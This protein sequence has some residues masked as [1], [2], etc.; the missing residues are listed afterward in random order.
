MYRQAQKVHFVG[1]GGI[2]MSGIAELL[3]NLGHQVS[4][5]DLKESAITRRLSEL[6]ATIYVGHHPD[7]VE[8]AEVVVYSSAV[9]PDNPEVAAAKDRHL[10][11]IR[12]AEM[13]AELMRLKYGIAVAGSHG[14]TTTTSLVSAALQAGGLDPTVVI[15]GQLRT[16]GTNVRLGQGEFLVAEADESDG[17]F[18]QLSPVIVVVTNVD[19]EHLDHYGSFDRIKDTF[20]EFINRV[21]FYGV[22][23]VCLDDPPLQ[24]LLPGIEKRV[25]TYGLS[26]QA[27]IRATDATAHGR[28]TTFTVWRGEERLG[29]MTIGFAGEHYVLNSLAAVAVA[30]E[31]GVDF[32]AFR[33]DFTDL[34]SVGRRF[35]IKGERA[36]VVVMDD[37]AHHPT[38][39]K[40]T[41]SGV[42]QSFPQ[43]RVVVV[44]QPHRYTRTRDLAD[45]FA[46]AFYGADV[47]LVSDIYPAGEKPI[48]GVSA[49]GLAHEAGAH[50]HKD[51]TYVG[52]LEAAYRRL[53]KV[54][55]AGDVVVTMGAGDVWRL[56]DRLLAEGDDD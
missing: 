27:D 26:A 16:L 33:N 8:G 43:R 14:K 3:I 20:V 23:I 30:V 47:V 19:A 41:L 40:A 7:Q 37:Y 12:R 48:P 44:F 56:G 1:I 42:R 54:A 46:T 2:G 17:S 50:G 39:I 22:A 29:E 10:P 52:D 5:S 13:L 15:G 53:R 45:R 6:G 9:T 11:V 34:W 49:E 18:L 25:I 28:Q 31:L 38:E 24:D 51:V 36:D 21:P 35:E 32:D 4:G 55:R